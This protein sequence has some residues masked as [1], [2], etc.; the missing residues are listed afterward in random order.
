MRFAPGL[1][2]L[3]KLLTLDIY[4]VIVSLGRH[5]HQNE[6]DNALSIIDFFENDFK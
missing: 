3:A 4:G 1:S 2:Y 5:S 6:A